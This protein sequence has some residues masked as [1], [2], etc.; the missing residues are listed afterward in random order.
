MLALNEG[1]SSP[2]QPLPPSRHIK[3]KSHGPGC[4]GTAPS[5]FSLRAS[6]E[7]RWEHPFLLLWLLDLGH[8]CSGRGQGPKRPPLA[9]SSDLSP[10]LPFF[11]LLFLPRPGLR[12]L[13]SPFPFLHCNCNLGKPFLI[14]LSHLLSNTCLQAFSR[15]H[16]QGRYAPLILRSLNLP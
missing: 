15:S 5:P 6:Q 9:T 14:F 13:F 2:V 16:P 11:L 4:T 3:F 7:Q 8:L 12:S 10:G 1:P